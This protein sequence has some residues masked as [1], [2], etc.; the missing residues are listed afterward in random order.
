[1]ASN[2]KAD[3]R[4][5]STWLSAMYPRLKLARELL[6]DDG[7]I[8]VSIDDNEVHNLR[9]IMNEVF[10]EE[11]FIANIVWQKRYVSNVTAQFMSDMEDYILVVGKYRE[12]VKLNKTARTEEQLEDYKNPD[13]DPRGVWRA[14]DLSASKPYAAG[15]FTITTPKGR[16]VDP[17]PGRYWRCNKA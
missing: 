14:Q 3:G 1:L 16:V 7:V 2:S 13:D 9:Q 11:H 5:H 6:R 4:F 12:S 8:F 15:V 17:P 10:G